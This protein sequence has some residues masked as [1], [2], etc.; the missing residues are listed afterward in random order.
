M[1]ERLRAYYLDAGYDNHAYS[2][3]CW[4]GNRRGRWIL[5][6]ASVPSGPSVS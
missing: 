5:I 6:S 3:R 2:P 1:M 4:R